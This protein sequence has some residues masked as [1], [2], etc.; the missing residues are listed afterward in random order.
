MRL[1]GVEDF[2]EEFF[3]EVVSVVEK[4]DFK[5]LGQG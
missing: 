5:T 4:G 2:C 1:G 3:G